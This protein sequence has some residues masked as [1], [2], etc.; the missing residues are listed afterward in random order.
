MTDGNPAGTACSH[1]S[2]IHHRHRDRLLKRCKG[3][4]ELCHRKGPVEAHHI[5][6]QKQGGDSMDS[7]IIMLCKYCHPLTFSPANIIRFQDVMASIMASGPINPAGTV[8]GA[9][10]IPPGM[11]PGCSGNPARTVLWCS[12]DSVGQILRLEDNPTGTISR[13]SDNPD[14][15]ILWRS[16]N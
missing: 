15:T 13:C 12:D 7:N 8:P 11:G 10:G 6:S 4:C 5:V 1:M 2:R 16:E 14:G 9:G 3:H